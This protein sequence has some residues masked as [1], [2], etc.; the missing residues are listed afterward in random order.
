MSI[1]EA[2]L[3]AT[4]CQRCG[5]NIEIIGQELI[6]MN[7]VSTRLRTWRCR[8][9]EKEQQTVDVPFAVACDLWEFQ[10]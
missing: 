4:C 9:C 8:N 10:R 7:G 5:G 2:H 6:D 1:H 3:S